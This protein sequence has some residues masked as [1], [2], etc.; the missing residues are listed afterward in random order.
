MSACIPMLQLLCPAAAAT[1]PFFPRPDS[2]SSAALPLD[3]TAATL[4]TTANVSYATLRAWLEPACQ[5][6]AA[7]SAS[8]SPERACTN[9]C[10]LL[11]ACLRVLLTQFS[12]DCLPPLDGL[13]DV[14]GQLLCHASKRGSA[15][16]QL[17]MAATLALYA[18]ALVRDNEAPGGGV[19]A[20]WRSAPGWKRVVDLGGAVQNPALRMWTHL[21]ALIKMQPQGGGAGVGCRSSVA[22]AAARA[23]AARVRAPARARARVCARARAPAT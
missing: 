22:A 14:A 13:E 5:L 23:R 3:E 9:A 1:R 17:A 10:L 12:Y 18:L 11:S 19:L 8:S 2:Q 4:A 20:Q 15:G 6:G 21:C 7:E 16:V